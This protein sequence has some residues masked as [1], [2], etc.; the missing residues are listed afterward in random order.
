V[1]APVAA[2]GA[3]AGDGAGAGAGAGANATPLFRAFAT[4]VL[5]GDIYVPARPIPTFKAYK[6]FVG[7]YNDLYISSGVMPSFI[8]LESNKEYKNWRKK[9]PRDMVQRICKLMRARDVFETIV[10]NEQASTTRQAAEMLDSQLAAGNFVAEGSGVNAFFTWLLD[11]KRGDFDGTNRVTDGILKS[12][13][14]YQNGR[15]QAAKT[16]KANKESAAKK[17]REEKAKKKAT[18]AAAEAAAAAAATTGE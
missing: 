7:L 15:A 12:L 18:E 16:A 6:T 4:S 11:P 17:R 9:V 5:T 13:K 3:A 10:S 2:A 14:L 8:E 1:V